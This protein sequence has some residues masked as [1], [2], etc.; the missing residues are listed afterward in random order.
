MDNNYEKMC[1]PL[2]MAL[3]HNESAFRSFLNMD[4]PTQNE[5]IHKANATGSVAE[6]NSLVNELAKK[7]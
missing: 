6:I 3:A 2:Q 1:V 7:E 4:I 5:F